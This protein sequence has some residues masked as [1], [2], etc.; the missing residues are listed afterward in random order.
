MLSAKGSIIPVLTVLLA[1]EASLGAQQRPETTGAF[2]SYVSQAEARIGQA[3]KGANSLLEL[4]SM[5]VPQR[6]EV[7]SRLRRGEVVVEKHGNTPTEVSG[8]LIHDWSGMVF[9]PDVTVPQ[10]LGMVR[11]YDHLA[12]YYSPDVVRSRLGSAHDD[13][14]HVFMRLRRQKVVTVVLDTEY[15]VHYGRIDAAHQYSTSRS[16]RVAEIA[17]PGGTDEHALPGDSDHGYMWRLNT[18]W[19]FEQVKDGVFVQC[20]AISLTRDIPSGLGWLIGPFLNSVPRESLQSTLNA[21]RAAL[22]K[23]VVTHQQE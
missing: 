13:D 8:G 15:D 1:A 19:A 23:T 20:E 7:I 17:D 16:T 18:Y 11:D 21:T 3:R 4:E 5:P 6:A 9:I 22:R 10:V 12:R 2:D 14:L